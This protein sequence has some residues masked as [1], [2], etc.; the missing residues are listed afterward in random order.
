MVRAVLFWA[1]CCLAVLVNG[2]NGDDEKVHPASAGGASTS[3]VEASAWKSAGCGGLFTEITGLVGLN[4]KPASW[5]DG[6]YLLPELTPGG[7]ALFD[8]DGDG[9][10][11]IL[12][13]CHPPPSDD[14][15]RRSKANR[16]FRQ[17][18]DGKFV[19][20][21]GAAGLEGKGFHNSAAIGDINNDGL[22][23]VYICNFG[24]PD[25]FFLNAGGEKFV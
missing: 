24:G 14:Q 11:D 20:V 23:D 1:A 17:T 15:F 3:G 6:K 7:V 19:E 12:I 2:C 5:P 18:E 8:F 16:L 9:R 22:P 13:V 25:E 10:L 4:D 21:S